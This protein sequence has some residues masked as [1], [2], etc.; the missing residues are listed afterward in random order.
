MYS[1][2]FSTCGLC[3]GS[4]KADGRDGRGTFVGQCRC[5]NYRPRPPGKSVLQRAPAPAPHTF[6]GQEAT[7]VW[8][9]EIAPGVTTGFCQV[10]PP[11]PA[12]APAADDIASG[13][14]GD[15]GGGGG[16]SSW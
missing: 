4:Y 7:H 10:D 5:G 1:S 6:Q 14:G 15:F 13:G 11:A 3:G 9:N 2:S 12:P 16:E 8:V